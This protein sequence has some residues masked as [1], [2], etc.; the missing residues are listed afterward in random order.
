MLNWNRLCVHVLKRLGISIR[1]HQG[2]L[3][4][5]LSGHTNLKP[6]KEESCYA[7]SHHFIQIFYFG[8]TGI[9]TVIWFHQSSVHYPYSSLS[10]LWPGKVLIDRQSIRL[11]NSVPI[12][13]VNYCHSGKNFHPFS[14]GPALS[15]L[16]VQLLVKLVSELKYCTCPTSFIHSQ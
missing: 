3:T 1:A 5:L 7:G 6:G 9:T 11:I 15:V 4:P 10:G 8:W 13:N 12:A 2:I 14:G 16:W